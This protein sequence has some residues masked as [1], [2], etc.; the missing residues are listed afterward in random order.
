MDGWSDG[1]KKPPIEMRGS[2]KKSN[3]TCERAEFHFFDYP[4]KKNNQ[5]TKQSINQSIN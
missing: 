2:I 1:R 4:Y 5:S 3:Q